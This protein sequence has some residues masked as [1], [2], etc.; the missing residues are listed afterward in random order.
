MDLSKT[1]KELIREI[2]RIWVAEVIKKIKEKIEEEDLIFSGGLLSSIKSEYDDQS[3]D[4]D[5]KFGM[6]DWGK[7]QDLGVNPLGAKLYQTDFQF[8]GN[9]A[10]TAFA[11]EEW[12]SQ[13]RLNNWAVASKLQFTKGIRPKNFFN[14]TIEALYPK[15]GE[16]IVQ[17]QIDKLKFDIEKRNK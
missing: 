4:G 12:A 7:F 16:R 3:V 8:K 11:L 14:S 6:A 9:V 15:L 10:G 1:T 2:E 5:F 13:K 17:L